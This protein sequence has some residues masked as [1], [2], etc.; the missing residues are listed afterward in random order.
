MLQLHSTQMEAICLVLTTYKYVP[1][2]SQ[3]YA[4]HVPLYVC[5]NHAVYLLTTS[6]VSEL[7]ISI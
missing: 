5:R 6:R 7:G 4:F 2:T 3:L 1:T